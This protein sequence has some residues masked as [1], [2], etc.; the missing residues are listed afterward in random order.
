M[1]K[2][3]FNEIHVLRKYYMG[4][5]HTD[6]PNSNPDTPI[7]TKFLYDSQLQCNK[8]AEKSKQKKITTTNFVIP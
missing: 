6:K 5:M 1:Q 8:I 2:V 7:I 4:K 3:I